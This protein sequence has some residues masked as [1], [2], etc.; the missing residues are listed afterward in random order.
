MAFLLKIRVFKQN[1]RH[2]EYAQ[3]ACLNS[4]KAE[5]MDID[6]EVHKSYLEKLHENFTKRFQDLCNLESPDWL[7]MN[8]FESNPEL[9]DVQMQESLIELQNDE[10]M[11][12]QFRVKGFAQMWFHAA[13]RY[14]ELLTRAHI[15]S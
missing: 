8:P 13:E 1:I 6:L 12:N 7:M 3:S 2:G 11:G 10:E 9:V 4:L 14:P 5:I 15:F